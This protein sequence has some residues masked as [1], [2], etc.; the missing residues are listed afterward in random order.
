MLATIL[1]RLSAEKTANTD[2]R[3]PNAANAAKIFGGQEP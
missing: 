1:P 3:L 2:A